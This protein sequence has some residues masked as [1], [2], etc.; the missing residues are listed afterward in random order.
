M[1]RGFKGP[2]GVSFVIFFTVEAVLEVPDDFLG[3]LCGMRLRGSR[4]SFRLF[5]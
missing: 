5:L 4:L 2:S 3:F 1:E